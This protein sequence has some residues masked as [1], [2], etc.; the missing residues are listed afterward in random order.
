[1]YDDYIFA[2]RFCYQ[3]TMYEIRLF[4]GLSGLFHAHI[5]YELAVAKMTAEIYRI[6]HY[7]A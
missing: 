5:A 2:D 3:L 7:I 1:M 6:S 4:V